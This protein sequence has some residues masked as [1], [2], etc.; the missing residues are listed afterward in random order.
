MSNTISVPTNKVAGLDAYRDLVSGLNNVRR[1]ADAKHQQA[2]RDARDLVISRGSLSLAAHEVE[3]I[4]AERLENRAVTPASVHSNTF[5]SN[6]SVAYANEKFIGE[7]L[8]PSIPV[9]FLSDEYA[10]YSKRDHLAA[11][12]DSMKGRSAANE[13]FD[14]R[15][16]A[17]YTCEGR[18][19]KKGL[20]KK[21]IDNQDAVF[22]EMMDLNTQVS[23]L[24]A[25]AREKRA[26]TVL[27]TS[28]NYGGTTAVAA[29]S[30][31]DSAGGGDPINVILSARHSI[32]QSDNPTK[33]IGFCPLS[34]YL[35]LVTHPQL[36][37]VTKYTGRGFIPKDVLAGL[38]ELDDL[39]VAK[40]WE[41]TANEGQTASYS[42]MLTSDVFGIVRVS[43]SPS[44]RSASF[45][46]NFRFKGQINNLT[47]FKQE[48]GTRGVYYNQQTADEV[49]KVVAGDTGHLITNCLA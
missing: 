5:L 2:W 16:S 39:L 19:L 29:G 3:R 20:E 32:W 37:D 18:G 35:K 7:T 31:W 42:R 45:G 36:L 21:T 34:V 48:E 11:P 15:T 12:D 14:N 4:L 47:W 23:H 30:E 43:M 24:L 17:S 6:L 33:V 49:Y 40:A 44:K 27:T 9:E 1:S 13:V 10:I 46:Y 25:F 22:D 41:D 8:L 26:M 28:G 38:F